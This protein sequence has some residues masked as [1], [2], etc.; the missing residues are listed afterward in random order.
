MPDPVVVLIEDEPQIRKFLR[1][2]LEG[3]GY[4]LF[5][6]T[7][8]ADGVV[9]VG[10]R[11]P[12]V[13]IVDLGLPDMDGLDVI[14]RVREWT[15]VPVIVLSA[16]GGERDKV[17]ALDAGADDYVGKPFGAGELLARIRVALR[18]TAGA[19]EY[20]LLTT[21]I[22]HAGKVVTH[23]QVL[24]EVWGPSHTEQ[25]HYVRVYMAHLRQKLEAEPARPRYLL[26]EPGV[27]YRLAAE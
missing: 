22:H 12:D 23:Q 20:R 8:G 1:A 24:R 18:H 27:G 26:T 6:A 9:E 16:R 11:Q 15:D 2:T 13:V 10:S 21:L 25:A 14:R 3:H 5:E 7:S 17:T 4:R 19:S